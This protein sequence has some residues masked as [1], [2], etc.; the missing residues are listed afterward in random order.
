MLGYLDQAMAYSRQALAH[1]QETGKGQQV[2]SQLSDLYTW[3]TEGLDTPD[4]QETMT[5][6]G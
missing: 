1:N 3:F 6:L 4:L 5:L 2:R